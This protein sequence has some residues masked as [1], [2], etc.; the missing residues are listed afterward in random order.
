MKKYSATGHVNSPFSQ[1]SRKSF[2]SKVVS[3]FTSLTSFNARYLS[4]EDASVPWYRAAIITER[5]YGKALMCIPLSTV[6]PL[7]AWNHRNPNTERVIQPPINRHIK[8]APLSD[9]ALVI[10]DRYWVFYHLNKIQGSVSAYGTVAKSLI[11]I[12]DENLTVSITTSPPN[13]NK[14]KNRRKHRDVMCCSG[15]DDAGN[16]HAHARSTPMSVCCYIRCGCPYAF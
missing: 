11:G 1:A 10:N 6:T 3:S 12:C 13:D 16:A 7:Y 9:K 4:G 8:D 5:E 2:S 14:R 15:A